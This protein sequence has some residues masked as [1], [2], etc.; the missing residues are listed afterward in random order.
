MRKTCEWLSIL[1][2]VMLAMTSFAF[3]EGECQHAYEEIILKAATC[4]EKGIAMQN[5]SLCGDRVYAA[6]EPTHTFGEEP[7]VIVPY[8]CEEEGGKVWY[9]T[10][11]NAEKDP[12]AEGVYCETTPAAHTF[13]GEIK[14]LP[15]TC[16][17]DGKFVHLCVVCGADEVLQLDEN[18]KAFGH[19]W[20]YKH[21][22]ASCE[23]PEKYQVICTVCGKI[24]WET[25][26]VLSAPVGHVKPE[27]ITVV[28]AAECE[29]AEIISWDCVTC[30]AHIEEENGA[31]LGH[32]IEVQ[33]IEEATCMKDGVAIHV[34]AA[35]GLMLEENVIL[36]ML[37][38]CEAYEIVIAPST[39]T[40]NGILEYRCKWCDEHLYFATIP[41][42]HEAG[43][44]EPVSNPTC[45][46]N[47][48]GQVHCMVCGELLKKITL[49]AT[50][51]AYTLDPVLKTVD[52][53]NESYAVIPC[54]ICGD[55][56]ICAEDE[57]KETPVH[58][59]AYRYIAPN[60]ECCGILE[61]YC[62]VCDE[63]MLTIEVADDAPLGH[64]YAENETVITAPDC[65][66]EGLAAWV[67]LRCNFQH[68][69]AKVAAL[70]HELQLV[71]VHEATCL[72][73]GLANRVCTVCEKVLEEDIILE[74]K[75]ACEAE[76]EVRIA[77]SCTH[78]GLG[79]YVCKWC[80]LAMGYVILPAS[81]AESYAKVIQEATCIAEGL[82][83]IACVH[84]D[85]LLE[86]NVL[87]LKEHVYS[88]DPTLTVAATCTEPAYLRFNCLNC[89]DE[90]AVKVVPAGDC[91]GHIWADETQQLPADCV[92][93]GREVKIC[94]TCGAESV[95]AY[96]RAAPALG[97]QLAYE[98]IQPTCTAPMMVKGICTVCNY[99]I[100]YEQAKEMEGI[101]TAALGHTEAE[102]WTIEIEP[103]CL[104]VGQRSKY[105]TVCG[106]LIAREE[107]AIVDCLEQLE[108]SLQDADCITEVNG[109]SLMTCKW[110][111]EIVRVDVAAFDHTFNDDA[112]V[113]LL[114]ATCETEGILLN[115]CEIC[116][117]EMQQ[118]IPATGHVTGEP[119]VVP[120]DCDDCERV[121]IYCN[122][123]H[124]ILTVEA[125]MG[126]A[127]GHDFG[128]FDPVI[129]KNVCI[130]CREVQP[131]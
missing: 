68:S 44:V 124:E 20:Q 26:S 41:F 104:T 70:G 117:Y 59:R 94:T 37:E 42:G 111:G 119:T 39:C 110:C 72:E 51:H 34:C 128:V 7:D 63:I 126:E 93:P 115:V 108:C 105:C 98:L 120:A 27:E 102:A 21:V 9:C 16:E 46:E 36:P 33:V 113:I 6:V 78:D 53:T 50:G 30:G 122:T 19:D 28:S 101:A 82:E 103:T 54:A 88:A 81:H 52:C 58:Q 35:C 99:E 4:T 69:E 74:K 107:I 62:A 131:D 49:P 92:T 38:D 64:I 24:R 3:A 61:V 18:A 76:I 112:A 8:T 47:G 91:L 127:L 90:S 114:E 1:L 56:L 5:C 71:T 25:E 48:L 65:E 86:E 43:D 106:E 125:E 100:E 130:Y 2:C 75:A 87:P 13:G 116:G 79:Q 23:E 12:E 85:M 45:N 14:Y 118:S 129:G 66:N 84:C 123:C 89:A 77:P 80:D 17:E 73:E 55:E 83:Q 67:C 40:E 97:H 10:V 32:T 11:C 31:A 29:K 22:E 57:E 109:V 15:A 96:D 60:C 121:V 95:I